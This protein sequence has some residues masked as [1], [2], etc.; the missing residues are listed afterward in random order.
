MKSTSLLLALLLTAKL[1]AADAPLSNS[2][3][4]SQQIYPGVMAVW[5]GKTKQESNHIASTRE[6]IVTKTAD[7]W[8]I[9]FREA[10]PDPLAGLLHT[11]PTFPTGD[12]MTKR[13]SEM[14][15]EL[16]K[17]RATTNWST[18][19]GYPIIR[20]SPYEFGLR[21]DGAVVWRKIAEPAKPAAPVAT[22]PHIEGHWEETPDPKGSGLS[23][24]KH[25][26]PDAPKA[27]PA[28]A[29]T[30]SKSKP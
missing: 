10:A 1:G 29:T 15:A 20:V 25:W 14:V 21:E 22:E 7:G 30:A 24:G 26:V 11:L 4:L 16:A 19:N 6:P 17:Q 27:A 8:V 2:A 12:D 3:S 5:Y 28:P 9:T 23:I 13:S 18:H